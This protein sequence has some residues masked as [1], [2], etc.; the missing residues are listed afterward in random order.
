M[1]RMI[2]R[3]DGSYILMPTMKSGSELLDCMYRAYKEW[4]GKQDKI[5]VSVVAPDREDLQESNADS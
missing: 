2:K 1:I 3:D 4:S 5:W